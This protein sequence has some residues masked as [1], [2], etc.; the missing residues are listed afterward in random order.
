MSI[1]S[2]THPNL[3]YAR[4][5]DRALT[6]DLYMPKTGTPPFPLIVW[7]HGGAWRVGD[8]SWC[9]EI[10]PLLRDGYAVAS[11][12][13]RLSTEAIFPAQIRDVKAAV[14]WLRMHAAEWGLD[15]DCFAAGGS[16]AGGHLAALL[17]VSFYRKDWDREGDYTEC[18]P[19]EVSSAVQ[20]VMD[21]Y[22]PTD[23]LTMNDMP[24][25]QDHFA[26]DSPESQLIGGPV[27]DYPDRVAASSPIRYIYPGFPPFLILHGDADR[28]VLP[29]Q[30][31]AFHDAL[32][33]RGCRSELVIIPGA[34]HGFKGED[35]H[36]AIVKARAFLQHE[37]REKTLPEMAFYACTPDSFRPKTRHAVRWLSPY[38]DY[39]LAKA[40]W[41][42]A[43]GRDLSRQSWLDAHDKGFS[44]AAVV[45]EERIVSLA[46]VFRS[47]DA[48]WELSEICTNDPANRCK[49]Y[50]TSACSFV[51]K[52]ILDTGH[53][54]TI[55]TKVGD[56][57]LGRL[58]EKIGFRIV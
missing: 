48:V 16:S 26:P 10:L 40:Y 49:G 15:A 30:S 57:A 46:A 12:E 31:T 29:N 36:H 56:Q 32:Q 6:L 39:E 55:S 20:A 37:L 25:D 41:N 3:I 27:K 7:I 58:V 1:I 42:F 44:Y 47:S 22:G 51:T 9:G 23:F 18:A 50:A 11:V 45:E 4:L 21:W 43:Q 13:Y 35:F 24:G 17:G 53:I 52:Y 8:K 38:E 54:A 34:G 14:R 19:Q 28:T 33:K 5:D 2:P